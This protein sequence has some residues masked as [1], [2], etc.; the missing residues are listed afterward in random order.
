MINAKL[1]DDQIINLLALRYDII[2]DDSQVSS[3]QLGSMYKRCN[4]GFVIAYEVPNQS[5][6]KDKTGNVGYNTGYLGLMSEGLCTRRLVDA[7]VFD[8]KL[9]AI[10]RAI[11]LLSGIN[12]GGTILTFLQV[13]AE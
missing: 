13:R 11:D 2:L 8:T 1:T 12:Y 9:A 4:S 3:S 6:W 5:I 7:V 10:I